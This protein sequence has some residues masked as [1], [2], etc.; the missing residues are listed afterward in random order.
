MRW[1]LDHA[2][3]IGVGH[4][5]QAFGK[6]LSAIGPVRVGMWVVDFDQDVVDADDVSRGD[7]VDVIDETA[8]KC[9]RN[10]SDGR[11]VRLMF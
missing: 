4:L 9:L 3:H 8:Q 11:S 1:P 5:K 7:A 6:T 2:V 10:S